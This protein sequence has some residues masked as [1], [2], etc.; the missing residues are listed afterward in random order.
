VLSKQRSSGSP[1]F[2]YLASFREMA[3]LRRLANKSLGL[4]TL[5]ET[6]KRVAAS[7]HLYRAAL[8]SE[9]IES[10]CVVLLAFALYVTLKPVDNLLA[11]IA[12]YW[13]LGE[14]FIAAKKNV[15]MERA[16]YE[17]EEHRLICVSAVRVLALLPERDLSSSLR[18]LAA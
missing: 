2:V 8:S 4:G 6:A 17:L 15:Y 16:R 18:Q 10:L 13:K 3:R 1:F 14:S 5:A 9:L 12:L 11:Q 7:E